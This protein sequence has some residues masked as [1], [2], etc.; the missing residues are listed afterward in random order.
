MKKTIPALALLSAAHSYG[1]I[2]FSELGYTN[3]APLPSP[4]VLSGPTNTA[5]VDT[6]GGNAY[7]A[8]GGY[9]AAATSDAS[10]SIAITNPAL[11]S[12]TGPY[13]ALSFDFALVDS[14]NGPDLTER[15]QFGISFRNAANNPLIS[16]RFEP[17]AQSGTPS[18]TTATWRMYYT[19]TGQA[20][21]NTTVGFNENDL[22]TMSFVFEPTG[23]NL[24]VT[25][26]Y[27]FYDAKI[28]ATPTGYTN[29]NISGGT[30]TFSTPG[31]A[32]YGTNEL[33]FDNIDTVVVVPEPS[34]ALLG[35]L[36][37]LGLIRRRRN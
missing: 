4:W 26:P 18:T 8:V 20:E 3:G 28:T 2:T 37:A 5:Y 13:G 12:T 15:N 16:V 23:V 19:V 9:N 29:T 34:A 1:A 22:F 30:L 17:I 35:A 11:N 27:S 14:F 31:S 36:G 7:G 24:L 21:V 25:S 6:I 33:I 10:A 32:T